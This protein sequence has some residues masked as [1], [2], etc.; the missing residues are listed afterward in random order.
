MFGVKMKSS[1]WSKYLD[2]NG[3]FELPKFLYKTNSELMKAVLDIG[4][5]VCQ[6]PT[7]LRAYKERVKALFK[8]RWNDIAG[9]LEFF[10]II[11]RCVC[12]EKDF[13]TICAGSRYIIDTALTAS[14]ISEISLVTG[15]NSS[16][17]IEQRL[18]DG[19]AKALADLESLSIQEGII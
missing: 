13:C 11:N 5:L 12:N 8:E 9:S 3:D 7:K 19:L 1:E 2:V 15:F 4:T 17:D 6:D 18:K 14:Q 10:G 16:D